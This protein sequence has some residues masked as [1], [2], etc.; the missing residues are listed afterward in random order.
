MR[1]SF[2]IIGA[3][4]QILFVILEYA[5][6]KSNGI[7]DY[8][9]DQYNIFDFSMPIFY[10]VH[11]GI[12]VHVNKIE[13]FGIY[14]LADNFIMIIL[15]LGSTSKILQYIRFRE[16][17]SFFVQM[18][19]STIRELIPFFIA[20]LLFMVVF[21]LFFFLMQ[22]DAEGQDNDYPG[23]TIFLRLCC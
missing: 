5:E 2:Y 17:F 18:F 1:W 9:S 8:F 16:E 13:D 4:T 19:F 20:F 10:F 6:I 14:K 22:C 7:K 11:I 3:F 15:I 21:S 12:R 23:M